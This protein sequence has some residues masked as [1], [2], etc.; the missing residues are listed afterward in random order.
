LIEQSLLDAK[1]YQSMFGSNLGV[2]VKDD[3]GR[4][5][6]R[7]DGQISGTMTENRVWPEQRTALTVAVNSDWGSLPATIAERLTQILFPPTG[8]DADALLFFVALQRRAIDPNKLTANAQS[9]FT[10]EAIAQ[11]GENMANLG[12]VRS[13]KRMSEGRRGGF[14]HRKYNILCARGSVS[15]SVFTTTDGQYEQ[16]QVE[17]IIR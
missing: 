2:F 4:R 5:L 12:S 13:F 10:A 11:I 14:I 1:G 17:P 15:A 16:F 8:A 7:H 6:I 3:A 9:Y